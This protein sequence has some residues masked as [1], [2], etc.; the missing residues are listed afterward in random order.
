MT[1]IDP[2]LCAECGTEPAHRDG[3]GYCRRHAEKHGNSHLF[4]TEI[5]HDKLRAVVGE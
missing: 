1:A 2:G 3:K 4:Y 5:D